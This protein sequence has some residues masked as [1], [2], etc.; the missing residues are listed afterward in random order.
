MDAD[1]A[2]FD[3]L[4][5]LEAQA[6]SLYDAERGIEL[7]DR[8]QTEYAQVP[9]TARL[10]ASVGTE[11]GLEVAGL[12]W[13]SG[14]LERAADGWCH[15]DRAGHDWVVPTAAVVAVQ[16]ASARAVPE[17]AWSPL[18]RLGWGTVLRRLATAGAPCALH[19]RDGGRLEGVLRRVGADFVELLAPS[20]SELLVPT[21]AVVALSSRA[22]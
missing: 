10:L 22:G 4:A 1:R 19:R 20:G 14:R 21:G 3:L 12:G 7:L 16:G 17:V 11:I 9:L 2:L 8:E 13:L 15:L 18:V 5:D 6:A